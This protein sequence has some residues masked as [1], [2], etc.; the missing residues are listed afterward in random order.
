[1]AIALL[2]APR[3]QMTPAHAMILARAI[4]EWLDEKYRREHPLTRVVFATET[5]T[6][7]TRTVVAIETTPLAAARTS[8][9]VDPA[10]VI[11]GECKENA[12]DPG[13]GTP[14]PPQSSVVE[15]TNEVAENVNT[16]PFE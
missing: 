1:M 5:V 14:Q 4:Q 6:T 12:A 13:S 10:V 2:P 16:T 7:T 11:D 15:I 8:V 9:R 3:T